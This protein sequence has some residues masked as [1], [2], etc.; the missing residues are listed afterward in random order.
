MPDDDDVPTP[1]GCIVF[2]IADFALSSKPAS[3]FTCKPIRYWPMEPL[4]NLAHVPADPTIVVQAF[5]AAA[6]L[7]LLYVLLRTDPEKAVDFTTPAPEQCR[8]GWRGRVLDDPSIKVP[9]STAIQCYAPATGQLL[10]LIN[11]STPDGIERAIT[12]ASAAQVAWTKTTFAQRRQ[13]LKT[14]L[15]FVLDNQDDIVRASCLDSGKTRV[16]ALFG[17]VLVTVE[18][19][20]WTINHGE[21]ALRT[22]QRP[23]NLLMFYK[24]NEVHYEPLG[25]VAACVSWKYVRIC[26]ST[27]FA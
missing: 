22:E 6:S 18:K 14:L 2:G 21:K 4:R 17:E 13:L 7:W 9:G 15:K 23:T 27:L 10:G 8:P 20:K 12:R 3:H 11:P 25:V 1:I 24:R 5:I 26:S 16:D 19:L